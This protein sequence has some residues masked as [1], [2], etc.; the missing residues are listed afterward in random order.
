MLRSLQYRPSLH[1]VPGPRR[2]GPVVRLLLFNPA[3]G[4]CPMPRRL[5]AVLALLFTV[6]LSINAFGQADDSPQ[7]KPFAPTHGTDLE[8]VSMTNGALN[9]TIPLFAYPQRGDLKASYSVRY[10]G[11][12]GWISQSRTIGTTTT[13][14]WCFNGGSSSTCGP[15][16]RGINN[17][18]SLGGN[19][20]SLGPDFVGYTKR[21]SYTDPNTGNVYLSYAFGVGAS[22]FHRLGTTSTGSSESIDGTGVRCDGTGCITAHG[23]RYFTSGTGP[24]IQDSNGNQITQQTVSPYNYTDSIGRSIPSSSIAAGT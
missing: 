19:Y 8:T 16:G 15:N 13:Y 18:P 11:N 21:S 9:V 6:S 17:Y 3:V 23:V 1:F 4:V 24:V 22:G 5:A 7:V 20:V 12:N 10:S 2:P 14:S